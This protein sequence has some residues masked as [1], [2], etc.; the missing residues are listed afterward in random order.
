MQST[1]INYFTQLSS[2]TGNFLLGYFFTGWTGNANIPSL[3]FANT[4]YSGTI[5]NT[6][7]FYRN[8]GSGFFDGNTIITVN[9]ASGLAA[10][11]W[12]MVIDYE[13]S[14]NQNSILFSNYTSGSIN[15]GWV[16]G[17]SNLCSPYIEYYSNN[18]PQIYISNNTWGQ[19][20][21]IFV[22]KT[23]NYINIDYLNYNTK[24]LESEQF[25]VDDTYFQPSNNWLIGG[26]TGAP[27]YFSGDK[28]KGHMDSFLY[29][30]PALLPYQKLSIS[31]GFYNDIYNST[32]VVTTGYSYLVTGQTT[33]LVPIFS[34]TTG[35]ANEFYNYLTGPCNNITAV[36]TTTGLTGII[37]DIS[38]VPL[39]QTIINLFTGSSGGGIIENTGFS[40]SHGLS[41]VSYIK[42]IDYQDITELYYFP[43][44]SNKLNINKFLELDG[45]LNKFILPET[46]DINQIN[47]YINGIGQ[48]GSG[49][50]QTGSIYNL[51]I[52]KSGMYFVS[53]IYLSGDYDYKDTNIVDIISGDRRYYNSGYFD[54]GGQTGISGFAQHSS[55]IF[56]DGF[57]L[58]SGLDY[59]LIN[60]DLIF[61]A[62]YLPLITSGRFWTFPIDS[63]SSFVSGIFNNTGINGYFA[64]DTTQIYMNGIRQRINIDYL[65]IP[66]ISLLNNSGLFL[67]NLTSINNNENSFIESI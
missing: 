26:H 25:I 12:T 35:N 57:K 7:N 59:K 16:L 39:T 36:Y 66:S 60:D 29:Y 23:N 42:N 28:Y 5:S 31:S 41:N 24:L 20:N 44:S 63:E 62:D 64:P 47:L 65:E 15:S 22:T 4:I 1:G 3:S 45:T 52:Q 61:Q 56:L 13:M 8:S 58:M 53:G 9:N 38:F 55:L 19:K 51:G 21:T 18:G 30:A 10:N 17:I 54:N 50:E 6:G 14:G 67:S 43:Q 37:Y 2:A 48:F 49:Y 34:G 11:T 46:Y 32:S 33:G 27:S 40:I